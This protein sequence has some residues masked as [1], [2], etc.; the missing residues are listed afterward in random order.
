MLLESSEEPLVS[1][2]EYECVHAVTFDECCEIIQILS[3]PKKNVFLYICMFLTE[4]LKHSSHNHL[5]AF[6]L[7]IVLYLFIFPNLY[8]MVLASI[9]GRVLLRGHGTRKGHY[10]ALPEKELDHRRTQFIFK[11]INNDIREFARNEFHL[12]Q[13][14]N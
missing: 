6:K 10:Q 8:I 13:D 11:F 2:L 12:V 7:G 14:N 5:D 3:S 1:P 4:L 9:F